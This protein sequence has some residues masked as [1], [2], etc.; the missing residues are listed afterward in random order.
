LSTARFNVD[1]QK[2]VE[3][4]QLV[5]DE[6]SDIEKA[7]V[8]DSPNLLWKM[9]HLEPTLYRGGVV[10]VVALLAAIGFGVSGSTTDTISAIV[11]FVAS[12]VQ[13]FWTRKSVT[14]NAKV[15]V[16]KPNPVDAPKQVA[17]GAAVSSDVV[18]VA[19]AAS[20]TPKLAAPILPVVF[21]GA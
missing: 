4:L 15:V 3:G 20:S 7:N 13:A 2:L 17:A 18:A 1:V 5:K 19:N 10:A 12:V 6:V 11:V 9:T 16:Y 14:A 8:P 21:P